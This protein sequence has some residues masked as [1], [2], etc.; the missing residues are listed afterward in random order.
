MAANLPLRIAVLDNGCHSAVRTSFISAINV[1]W[2]W[3]RVP[4]APV[5]DFHD[6]TVASSYP[7][8][9]DYDLIVLSGGTVDSIYGGE[10]QRAIQKLIKFNN[11]CTYV[12]KFKTRYADQPEIWNKFIEILE[13]SRRNPM[14]DK[15][16]YERMTPLLNNTPDLIE[17]LR[18]ILL[19]PQQVTRAEAGTHSW[20]L[21]LR[22]FVRTAVRKDKKIVGIGWGHQIICLS[23]NGGV[24]GDMG[25]AELG[26]TKLNL[27]EKGCKM[28]PWFKR[29]GRYLY[30]H[31]F[32][33][34]EVK[35]PANGFVRLAD[36]N[37]A[38]VSKSNKVM[39]IQGH[40]EL[41]QNAVMMVLHATPEYMEADEKQ[42]A[43]LSEKVEKL[44]DGTR[45]WERILKWA[46]E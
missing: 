28:F 38:F 25:S 41:N 46:T 40:P 43:A 5:V 6:A 11:A 10:P 42:R 22:E 39:T 24:V 37:K 32:H 33:R 15:D 14:T 23:L 8:P 3:T 34:H 2:V 29:W 4:Y 9:L 44:G 30:L 13:S 12:N 17:G 7:D 19:A 20:V 35:N 26:L 1:A 36:G 16:V 31:E 45:V 18:H 21:K 27:T